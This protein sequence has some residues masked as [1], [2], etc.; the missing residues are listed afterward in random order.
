MNV[1]VFWCF[2]VGEVR[3]K[4]EWTGISIHRVAITV[5][6]ELTMG[7]LTALMAITTPDRP[8]PFQ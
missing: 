2:V 7:N 1:V 6:Y 3:N 5:L 8:A 4:K